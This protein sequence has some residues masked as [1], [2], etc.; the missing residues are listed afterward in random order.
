MTNCFIL[1]LK[2]LQN[3]KVSEWLVIFNN[4]SIEVRE[5]NFAEPKENSNDVKEKKNGESLSPS[6]FF[7]TTSLPQ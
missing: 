5:E 7:P 4:K 1:S 6:A 3:S 2:S